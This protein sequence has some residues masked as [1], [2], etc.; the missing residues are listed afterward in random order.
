MPTK[1]SRR[2]RPKGS[3]L[4]DSGHISAIAAVIAQNPDLKPTTAI[5]SLGISDPSTIR[6]LRDKYR[7]YTTEIKRRKEA[8]VKPSNVPEKTPQKIS[9]DGRQTA[10]APRQGPPRTARQPRAQKQTGRS[11]D[12]LGES[13]SCD[14]PAA[15]HRPRSQTVSTTIGKQAA[16]F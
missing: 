16:A 11:A 15:I 8:S 6:R 9:T 13:A 7:A 2:G 10:F 12:L 1:Q 14:Q 3:G 5:K 4:D